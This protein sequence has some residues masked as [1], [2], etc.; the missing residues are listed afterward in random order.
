MSELTG[1]NR[2]NGR[3][4]PGESGNPAGRPKGA[5]N[6][7]TILAERL[8]EQKVEAVVE[9]INEH[10][11]G[12]NVAAMRLFLDRAAPRT[13]DRIEFALPEL[14]TS[15]DAFAAQLAL[16]AAVAAGEVSPREAER[17]MGLLGTVM[18]TLANRERNARIAERDRGYMAAAEA[19]RAERAAATE[20]AWAAAAESAGRPR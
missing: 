19:A 1:E 4:G 7:A 14:L 5:R 12:G 10:A 11:I 17:M 13:R 3:F 20:E 16:I 6:K 9:K 2:E 8:F 15:D 18:S